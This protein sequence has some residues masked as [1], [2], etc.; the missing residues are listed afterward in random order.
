VLWPID[1]WV[2]ICVWFFCSRAACVSDQEDQIVFQWLYVYQGTRKGLLELYCDWLSPLEFP[3]MEGEF[4]VTELL[5]EINDPVTEVAA[6]K[7]VH[8][9]ILYSDGRNCFYF[10]C[11]LIKRSEIEFEFFIGWQ[12]V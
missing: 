3:K 10:T 9:I 7:V 8:C 5:V 1:S 2:C 4:V 6:R 12:N 11:F